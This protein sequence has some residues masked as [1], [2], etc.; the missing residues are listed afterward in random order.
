MSTEKVD[1]YG[2]ILA[3]AEAK[4][5]ALQELVASVKKAVAL[6]A[7]GPSG[8]VL[9]SASPSN[10]EAMDLPVGAFSGLSVPAAVK[11]YLGAIKRKQT[12]PQ[13][14]AAL[15]DG[16]MESTASNFYTVVAGALFRL[17]QSNEILRFKDGWGLASLYPEH[18]RKAAATQESKPARKKA[19]KPTKGKAKSQTKTEQPEKHPSVVVPITK[20]V[21]QRI[22]GILHASKGDSWHPTELA[23]NLELNVTGVQ[24]TLGRMAAKG[25]VKKTG[26]GKYQWLNESQKVG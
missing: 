5:A 22:S 21:E 13:I 16:G 2:A 6:G 23:K 4:I 25:L 7:S 1:Y 19:K 20:S 18:I 11:L 8:E 12:A 26:D 9:P 24:L 14:V 17:K 3:D 10:N 15:K